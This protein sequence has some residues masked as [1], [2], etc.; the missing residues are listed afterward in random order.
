MR[1]KLLVIMHWISSLHYVPDLVLD[2]LHTLKLII[3]NSGIQEN[4]QQQWK[5]LCA[6]THTV[7][8]SH[9]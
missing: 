2:S 4:F 5:V 6:L 9:M 7:A 8:T 1:Q 3:Y